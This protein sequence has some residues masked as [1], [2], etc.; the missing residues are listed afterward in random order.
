MYE[1]NGI[2]YPIVVNKKNNK[3][4]YI[5]IK[6]GC[7]YITTSIF[8]SKKMINK[9]LID[10]KNAIDKMLERYVNREKKNIDF[11]YLGH[12]Y[13]IIMIS[14]L[15]DVEVNQNKIYARDNKM[16][17]RW[18]NKQMKSLFTERL[19]Y[20]YN[21]FEENIVYP[22]L[23]IRTMKTRWGVCNNKN[24]TITLNSKLM[25]YEIEYIDYVVIH[26]LC[27]LVY[28]NHSKNFWDLVNKHCP[29]YKKLRLKL[30]E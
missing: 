3:H 17:N 23:K 4:T 10:N 9:L 7:V 13:D 22:S 14:T 12:K 26:E 30:R 19:N 25:R 28:P 2:N 29:E 18:Y 5:K 20:I 24:K 11:Y 6:D 15:N 8:T 21:L 16:L 1:F 27:H